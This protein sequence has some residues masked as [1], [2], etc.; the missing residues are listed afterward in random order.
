VDVLSAEGK[1][2]SRVIR[3]GLSND[4]M[5]EI[6]DGLVE[7]DQVVIPTTT[8]RSPTNIPG[9]FGG[10]VVAPGAGPVRR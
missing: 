5:T 7:G 8:T 9:G 3:R 10:P 1:V 4:Q 6:S 2:E